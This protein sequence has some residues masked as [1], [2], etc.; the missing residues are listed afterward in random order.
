MWRATFERDDEDA[1][2]HVLN[3]SKPSN[4]WECAKEQL[5]LVK[6]D[7]RFLPWWF[8]DAHIRYLTKSLLDESS[9]RHQWWLHGPE[10]LKL[11]AS[12][13]HPCGCFACIMLQG[14]CLG[15]SRY[16]WAAALVKLYR[17]ESSAVTW[18]HDCSLI[19]W[20]RLTFRKKS[21]EMESCIHS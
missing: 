17:Q 20:M 7:P 1:A 5:Y 16:Y 21:I 11:K 2:T 13:I 19:L 15:R 6:A 18:V 12:I 14:P 8:H 10:C 3:T 4:D 9:P